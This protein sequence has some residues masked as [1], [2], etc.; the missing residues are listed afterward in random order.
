MRSDWS[1]T[2]M[3]TAE[4]AM[5]SDICKPQA[6][7]A[8]KGRAL[9]VHHLPQSEFFYFIEFLYFPLAV[10]GEVPPNITLYTPV[11]GRTPG[12]AVGQACHYLSDV[13]PGA[14]RSAAL[15]PWRCT[16]SPSEVL[17]GFATRRRKEMPQSRCLNCVPEQT[18]V[19]VH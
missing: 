18:R 14:R 1:A 6:P 10:H 5:C 13:C 12:D 8:G 4:R 3:G 11:A 16:T 15:N 7:T 2:A 19:S 9:A 17:H